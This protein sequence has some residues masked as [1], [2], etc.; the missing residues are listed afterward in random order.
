LDNNLEKV[1]NDLTDQNIKNA[2]SDTF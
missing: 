1:K 2:I